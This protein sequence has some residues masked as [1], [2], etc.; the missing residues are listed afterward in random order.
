MKPINKCT[1]QAYWSLP[2]L[3]A[4]SKYRSL[5]VL[6]LRYDVISKD[7]F[8]ISVVLILIT[9]RESSSVQAHNSRY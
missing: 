7:K 3:T 4:I 5:P 6:K 8:V 9:E 2:I 1:C